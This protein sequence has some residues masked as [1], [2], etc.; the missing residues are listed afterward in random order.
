V[1]AIVLDRLLEP[2]QIYVCLWADAG[3]EPAHLHYIVQPITRA[4][5]D[6]HG[7]HGPRLQAAMFADGHAPPK[8]RFLAFAHRARLAFTHGG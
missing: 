7:V 1:C 8:D 4:L 5:M 2:E 3:G 6:R